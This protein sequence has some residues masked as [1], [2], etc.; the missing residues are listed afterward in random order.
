[1]IANGPVRDV[2]TGGSYFATE[3]ARILAGYHGAL[4]PAEGAEALGR[5]AVATTEGAAV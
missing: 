1:V 4:T 3:T 5:L 2:L